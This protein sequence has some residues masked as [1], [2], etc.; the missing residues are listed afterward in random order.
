MRLNHFDRPWIEVAEGHPTIGAGH[1][2]IGI[3]EDLL[4]IRITP[5][6]LLKLIK[7]GLDFLFTEHQRLTPLS[8]LSTHRCRLSVTV[9]HLK[10][11]DHH[12]SSPFLTRH[13]TGTH[14]ARHRVIPR[15]GSA[16]SF[17]AVR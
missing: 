10:P 5:P 3:S 7:N 4:P 11:L 14:D 15:Y 2:K 16:A 1:G 6:F 17:C 9:A 8:L 12:P 13:R